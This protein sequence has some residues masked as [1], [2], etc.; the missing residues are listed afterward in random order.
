MLETD[1]LTDAHVAQEDAI[2]KCYLSA[3]S[4]GYSVFALQDGGR[5][6]S[7]TDAED[8][9]DMYGPSANCSSSGKGGVRANQV[10]R[11]G[12]LFTVTRKVLK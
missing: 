11:I 4:R 6:A 10:Y 7:S 2:K 8:T 3:K 5:C 9:Y 1:P 12:K